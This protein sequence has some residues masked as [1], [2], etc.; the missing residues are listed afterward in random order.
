MKERIN[1]NDFIHE[2]VGEAISQQEV[3]RR[4]RVYDVQR[5]SFLFNLS[6]VTVV[7]ATRKGNKTKVCVAANYAVRLV[8][9]NFSAAVHQPCKL[10]CVSKQLAVQC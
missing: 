7:D 4:G 9:T 10:D 5:L 6:D 1:K 2:Y 8:H 3:E